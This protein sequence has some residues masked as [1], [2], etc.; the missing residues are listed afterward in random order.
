MTGFEPAISCLEGRCHS[1]LDH[2][3]R[4]EPHGR[5]LRPQTDVLFL[6][7]SPVFMCLFSDL[8]IRLMCHM[9]LEP[10]TPGLKVRC[11]TY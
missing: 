9:G 6:L 11:S 10:M 4:N 5:I 2:I 1:Q 3:C 8:D 7:L